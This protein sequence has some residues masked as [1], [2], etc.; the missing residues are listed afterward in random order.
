[1]LVNPPTLSSNEEVHSDEEVFH[2]I[3][4]YLD[5]AEK[6]T[7][8]QVGDPLQYV[9]SLHAWLGVSSSG[10]AGTSTSGVLLAN[11]NAQYA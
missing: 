6:G 8:V 10:G 4:D 5:E 9:L 11:A 3:K 2:E 7:P 1:M